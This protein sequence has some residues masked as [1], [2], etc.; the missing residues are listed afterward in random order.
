[1]RFLAAL[2]MTG[3]FLRMGGRSGDSS[4]IEFKNIIIVRIAAS[5]S[6]IIN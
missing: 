3:H 4:K 2:G 1:M 5:P 6:L